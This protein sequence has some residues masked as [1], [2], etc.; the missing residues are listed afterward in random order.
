[1][2]TFGGPA[3][4]WLLAAALA[5][6]LTA[7]GE[8]DDTVTVDGEVLDLV[9]LEVERGANVETHTTSAFGGA[10]FSMSTDRYVHTVGDLITVTI[11]D[12]GYVNVGLITLDASGLP[13]TSAAQVLE[14]TASIETL[15][16]TPTGTAIELFGYPLAGYDIT[17]DPEVSG[18]V[19]I[20]AA[21][22]VGSAPQALYSLGPLSRVYVGDTPSGPLTAVS[23]SLFDASLIDEHEL[24]LGSL[25]E[26]LE[27][28]GTGLDPAIPPADDLTVPAPTELPAP[29]ELDPDGPPALEAV[30][31]P[32]E[33]GRY[34]LANLGQAL[35]LDVGDDWFV[36]PNFPGIV[37]LTVP[38]SFGPGDQDVVMYTG[39]VDM[40]PVG[41]GPT[42]GGEAIPLGSVD[43]VLDVLEE[44]ADVSGVEVV[45]L[46][47][48]E[49]TRF[50]VSISAD[51]ACSD[52]EPCEFAFRSASGFVKPLRSTHDHR[53]WW[54]QD[55]VVGPTMIVAMAGPGSSFIDRADELV[56]SIDFG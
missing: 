54:I 26:S 41:P 53:I 45:D 18:G 12:Q 2:K 29:A 13:V 52:A 49:A 11:G 39:V 16:I 14:A 9:V 6:G 44:S 46:G 1:M 56:G 40:L 3:R 34:Q 7:C 27:L 42:A 20:H 5:V 21:D 50:D 35:S 4:R 22:R 8:G 33:E 55:G 32:V 17:S 43:D 23:I 24:V 47:G 19:W 31:S 25:I 28:T 10:R 48:I 37:V 30:F 51:A 38:G 36:Q 15:E